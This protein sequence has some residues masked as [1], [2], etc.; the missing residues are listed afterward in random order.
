MGACLGWIEI[1]RDSTTLSWM[2]ILNQNWSAPWQLK[3]SWVWKSLWL[4]FTPVN[5]LP[6]ISTPGQRRTGSLSWFAAVQKRQWGG[7]S[8]AE[9]LKVIGQAAG[10]DEQV[11]LLEAWEEDNGMGGLCG[12]YTPSRCLTF[13]LRWKCF[14]N[15]VK[16]FWTKLALPVI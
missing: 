10:Q 8:M 12:C 7:V 14:C 15:I 3:I 16:D 13:S 6:D 11:G 1:P 9:V 4:P 2:M 5:A